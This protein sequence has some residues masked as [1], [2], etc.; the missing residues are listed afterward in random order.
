LSPGPSGFDG[1]AGA[2]PETAPAPRVPS[3]VRTVPP[4]SPEATRRVIE[5]EAPGI[6]E[7]IRAKGKWSHKDMTA[8]GF[9]NYDPVTWIVSTEGPFKDK[10]VKDVVVS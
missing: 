8:L 3:G 2:G 1:L 6:C 10:S 5:R 7:L 9:I 4:L